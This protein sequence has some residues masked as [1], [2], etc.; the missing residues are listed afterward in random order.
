MASMCF[1][2]KECEE[3]NLFLLEKNNVK[4]T[5]LAV[6]ACWSSRWIRAV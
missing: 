5:Y 3:G 2:N 6:V 1:G 4:N